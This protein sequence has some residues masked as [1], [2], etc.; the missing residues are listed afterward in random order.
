MIEW[1]I[2]VI[3]KVSDF[4]LTLV[5]FKIGLIESNPIPFWLLIVINVIILGISY[6]V[7]S[8]NLGKLFIVIVSIITMIAVLNN[9]LIITKTVSIR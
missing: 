5:G 1:L 2:L 7:K 4:S 6:D 8:K 3:L 9:L